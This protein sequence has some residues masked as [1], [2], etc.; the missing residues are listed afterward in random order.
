MVP[1]ADDHDCGWKAYAE[2]QER[3]ADKLEERLTALEKAFK[4]KSERR[5]KSKLP[6]AVAKQPA[7]PEEKK[8]TRE[9]M[10]ALREAK[11]ETVVEPLPVAPSACACEACGNTEL[12]EVGKGKPSTIYEYI[13]PSFRKLV[14]MRQTLACKCGKVI[15]AEAP[16]R[17]GE[18]TRYAPSFVA[19]LCTSKLANSIPQHRLEKE[20]KRLGIPIARSTMNALLHRAAKELK[21]LHDAACALVKNGRVVGAD[22]TSVRQADLDK[23]AFMWTFN[24]PE[25]SVYKYAETRS[26]N[27]AVEMLGES[28]GVIVVDQYT[29]YNKVTKPGMRVRAGCMAH[30]RRKIF[31]NTSHE[32]FNEALD[33]IGKL[34][35]VEREAKKAGIEKAEAHLAMRTER[36]RPLF[37]QLLWWGRKQRGRHEPRSS[38]GRAVKYLMKNRRALSVF[39]TDAEV[40]IDNN[41]SERDMRPVAMGRSNYLFFQHKDS[42]ERHATLY[43]LV[44]SAEKN[45]LNPTTYLSD[46]LVRVHTHPQNRIEDLL[47]HRWKPPDG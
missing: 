38:A 8:Q 26:G 36:S 43:T 35:E 11:L 29:G 32:G 14:L 37:A 2:H 40:P 16:A 22:E 24:T 9:A 41:A 20:Y 4:R 3:R 34:Y 19:H 12:R 33:L 46:V 1:P 39:L 6:P 47:P 30:A 5:K 42:G 25:L 7:T 27:M 44:K 18:K 45:G 17:L 31:E 28:D 23:K 15:T 10:A 13:P 21:P